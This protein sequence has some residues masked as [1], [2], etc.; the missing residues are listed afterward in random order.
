MRGNY[1]T[2]YRTCGVH[3]FNCFDSYGDTPI[4]QFS[5]GGAKLGCAGFVNT[6]SCKEAYDELK[7]T[8]NIVYQSTPRQNSNSGRQFFFVVYDGRR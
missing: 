2:L 1:H 7:Q 8:F 3:L 5:L 6:P 4:S